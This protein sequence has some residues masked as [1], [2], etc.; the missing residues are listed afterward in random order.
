MGGENGSHQADREKLQDVRRLL[1]FLILAV[2]CVGCADAKLQFDSIQLGRSLNPDGT[3][4]NHTTRFRTTDTIYVSILTSN[5]GAGT[6]GVRWTFAGRLVGEPSKPI[7]TKGA[8]ATEF[9]L[10]NS[11]GFPPGDYT[12]EAFIDGVAVAN[13]PFRVE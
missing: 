13:R 2:S 8:T 6:V 1:T 12:V 3:V 7:R 5:M 9:H 4:G 11:S 10:A